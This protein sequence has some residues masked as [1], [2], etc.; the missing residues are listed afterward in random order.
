[1]FFIKDYQKLIK[2][3]L[4]SGLLLSTIRLLQFFY[5]LFINQSIQGDIYGFRNLYGSGSILIV[6]SITL[7]HI[8]Y[9]KRANIINAPISL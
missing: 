1:M 3:I 6:L 7:I 9:K 5:E 8:L 2:L 4:Y